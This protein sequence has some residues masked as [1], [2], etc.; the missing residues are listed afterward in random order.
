[1]AI[2]SSNTFFFI[3]LTFLFF[4]VFYY[5]YTKLLD[6]TSKITG[7]LSIHFSSL[8]S[9]PFL[10]W[11]TFTDLLLSLLYLH[12]TGSYPL[13]AYS[14]ALLTQKLYFS[15]KHLN[16][17]YNAFL[18][19]LISSPTISTFSCE[20][21]LNICFESS[22]LLISVIASSMVLLLL[23]MFSF[24]YCYIVLLFCKIYTLKIFISDMWIKEYQTQ[25][26]ILFCLFIY[27][28]LKSL[29]S[30]WQLGLRTDQLDSS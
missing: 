22:R 15:V 30:L 1:M 5:M 28:K 26:I 25:S 16:F 7:A 18:K 2:I 13:W 4:W 19:Q 10:V 21:P 9:C 6:I 24:N 17:F 8:L 23:I 14:M 12:Y 27:Q 20:I 11:I 29:S 3:I